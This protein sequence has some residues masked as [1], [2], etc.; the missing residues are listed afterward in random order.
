MLGSAMEQ[1][2]RGGGVRVGY[3]LFYTKMRGARGKYS[4]KSNVEYLTGTTPWN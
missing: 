1:C 4:Y 2:V 3:C